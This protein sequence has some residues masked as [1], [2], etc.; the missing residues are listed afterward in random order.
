MKNNAGLAVASS[1]IVLWAAHLAYALEFVKPDP[2]SPVFYL[3]V[4]LQGYLFTGLFITAHDS[5]H[6]AVS[7]NRVLN[8]LAGRA[9]AFLFAGMSYKRLLRNHALHHA[10]PGTGKDPDY[11][12]RSSNFFV[13][14]TVF[15]LRYATFWQIAVM[16]A[17][18]NLLK[19]RYPEASIVSFW[20]V[21]AFIGT[22]QLFF[23]G[24]YIPHRPP[25]T[26]AMQ[27]HN[28]RTLRRNHALAM[29]TCYFFG[30]HHE[31]HGNPSVPWWMLHSYKK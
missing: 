29:L 4:L 28:A 16:A 18:Y 20:V 24:T 2:M 15:F 23:F 9:C 30:Y 25:H 21:P 8:R 22:F 31:H 3:H 17:A 27:P 12:A 1:I 10:H 5:M 11:C 7:R 13:W 26:A 19:L 14:W 6:G